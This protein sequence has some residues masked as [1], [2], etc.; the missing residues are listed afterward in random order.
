MKIVTFAPPHEWYLHANGWPTLYIVILVLLGI[1]KLAE[2]M[3]GC[4]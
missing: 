1:W 2:L 3:L 4:L